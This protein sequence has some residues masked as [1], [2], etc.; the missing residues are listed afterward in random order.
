MKTNR[1]VQSLTTGM[2]ALLAT[3]ALSL[4]AV[5]PP[6]ANQNLAIP[7]SVFNN[8]AEADCRVCHEDPGMTGDTSNVDR[9]HLRMGTIVPNPTSAPNPPVGGGPFECLTCHSLVWNPVNFSYEFTPFRDCL[10]CHRQIAGQASV[11]H[12]TAKAEARDCVACH[13]DFVTNYNDGHYIPTYNPSLVTPWPSGKPNSGPDGEGNCTFCHNTVTGSAD[14]VLDPDSGVLVYRNAETHHSTGFALDTLKCA[15]CHNVNPPPNGRSIRRC[16]RCHG[17]GT[18]HNIQFDNAGD[19]IDPGNEMPYYGHIG[20]DDDC[21]GCH[22]FS[23]GLMAAAALTGGAPESGPV[24]PSVSAL[25]AYTVVAGESRPLTVTGTS[26][27]NRVL[28][29]ATG[30]YDVTLTSDVALTDAAGHVT[31][32]T[33]VSVSPESIEVVLPATLA[34]GNYK[35]AAVKGPKSSNPVGIAVTPPVSIDTATCADGTVSITGTGFSSHV[36]AAGSGTGVYDS[37]MR[38]GAILSWTDT[39]IEARFPSCTN[40]VE[41]RSVFGKDTAVIPGQPWGPA[42]V[43]GREPNPASRLANGLGMM[44]LPAAGILFWNR[45]ARKRGLPARGV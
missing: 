37:S 24:I 33:T 7:D 22:G 39:A 18:L 14:P 16:E 1:L 23:S 30:A 40:V 13:G 35:L 27:V 9:H 45:R 28:N 26:F 8:Q 6:P 3:A 44:I 43:L 4:A 17:L 34:V 20:N 2:V 38:P 32:L 42:S 31:T 10:L 41:V 19:G 15:W 21:W 5:P 25:S 29:P 11:H 36:D 12:L